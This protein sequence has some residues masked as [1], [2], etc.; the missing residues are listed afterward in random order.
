MVILCFSS[1]GT[2]LPLT[3]AIVSFRLWICVKYVLRVYNCLPQPTGRV[4]NG[5]HSVDPYWDVIIRQVQCS[6]QLC[7]YL[8]WLYFGLFILVVSGR[9]HGL[10]LEPWICKKEGQLP[11]REGSMC[12]KPIATFVIFCNDPAICWPHVCPSRAVMRRNTNKSPRGF[13]S[14]R[15]RKGTP[16][17]RFI[18]TFSLGSLFKSFLIQNMYLNR[19]N[20]SFE[21]H[22]LSIQEEANIRLRS[23]RQKRIRDFINR[24]TKQHNE[25]ET[26]FRDLLKK[27]QEEIPELRNVTF[28][29]RPSIKFFDNQQ[30]IEPADQRP[31]AEV[32]DPP[33]EIR[34]PEPAVTK[35]STL[36]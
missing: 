16:K 14:A 7:T 36:R 9:S 17:N 22:V 30:P 29:E 15:K 27:G 1:F 12:L 28:A 26:T 19:Y 3:R 32:V 33:Q 6:S 11:L 2:A 35:T 18:P 23:F 21:D 20:S 13:F 25:W 5:P 10:L 34:P 31:T 8:T 4:S 24:L